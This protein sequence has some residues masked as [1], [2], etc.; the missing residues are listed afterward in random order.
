MN[1]GL[2]SKNVAFFKTITAFVLLSVLLSKMP[3][4]MQYQQLVTSKFNNF[5]TKP[6]NKR[7]MGAVAICTFLG[8]FTSSA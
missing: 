8:I 5:S 4:R 7:I 2:K 6:S 1:T 3:R